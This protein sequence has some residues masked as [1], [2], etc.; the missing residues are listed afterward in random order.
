[1]GLVN[2]N[3][4]VPICRLGCIARMSED[5]IKDSGNMLVDI[6]N[7]PGNSGSPIVLRPEA[8]SIQGTKA[9]DRSVLVGIIHSY[10]PYEETLINSQTKRPVEIRSENSG[11]A[12]AHPVEYIREIIDNLCPT[13]ITTTPEK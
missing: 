11:I 5:Q 1:M 6:Q 10:I 4:G 8:L 13:H 9:L 3:S 2:N 7:F 12:N